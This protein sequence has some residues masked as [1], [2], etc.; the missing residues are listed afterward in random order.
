MTAAAIPIIGIWQNIIDEKN[1]ITVGELLHSLQQSIVLLG[2]AFNSLS[3]FRRH[4]LKSSLSPEFAPLIKGLDSDHKPSRFLS[5]DELASKIKSLSEENKFLK[6]ISS[7]TI[8]SLFV[9]LLQLPNSRRKALVRGLT[10][11][12]LFSSQ[13][14]KGDKKKLSK[15]IPK[16]R[17]RKL[18]SQDPVQVPSHIP[19]T[20][21]TK[22]FLNEWVKITNSQRAL[23]I[24]GGYKPQFLAEPFQSFQPKTFVRN[25]QEAKIIQEEIDTLLEKEAIEPIP[26][27]QAKFVSNLF[28]VK[29]KSGGFRTRDKSQEFK[30]VCSHRALYNGDYYKPENNV[31]KGRLD[32][33]NRYFRCLS[34]YSSGRRI[35]GLCNFPISGSDDFCACLLA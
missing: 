27:R 16:G 30:S 14:F 26:H 28:L 7:S 12:V 19:M 33:D 22:Y 11:D 2:S 4:R 1:H 23:N 13:S 3:S 9:R 5:E 20:G 10:Q 15:S 21:R 31:V 34:H 24:V 32:C 35:Q 6:K 8:K 18:I 25:Q 29:K 17:I